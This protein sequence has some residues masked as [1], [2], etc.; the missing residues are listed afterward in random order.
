MSLYSEWKKIAFEQASEEEAVKFWNEYCAVEKTIYEKVLEDP[1]TT[2]KGT[3]ADLA[4]E[5]GVDNVTFTGFIDGINTSIEQEID[6]EELEEG[7]VVE[8]NID[9]EKLY[10][11][12]LEAKADWLYTLPKWEEILTEEKRKEI[13]KEYNSTKTIV[14]EDKIGRNDACSCGSGKKY[15]KCCGK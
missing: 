7:T 1:T 14:K 13:R 6:L 4:L 15:K 12:M 2:I 8:L 5:Y 3:V 10:F 11:N 9:M